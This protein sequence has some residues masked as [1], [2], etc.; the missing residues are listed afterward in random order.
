ML[1]ATTLNRLYELSSLVPFDEGTQNYNAVKESL[2]EMI[3]LVEAVRLVETSR[4]SLAGRG[5]KEDA[6]L[7]TPRTVPSGGA[8]Q[9]LLKHASR[10]SDQFYV[11]DSERMQ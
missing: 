4:V 1:S 8:G 2:E 7:G 9:E 6:D 3:K 11:V 10:K 5:E